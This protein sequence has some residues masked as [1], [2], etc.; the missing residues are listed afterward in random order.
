MKK[1]LFSL[2]VV[3]AALFFAYSLA[4]LWNGFRSQGQLRA[5]ADDRLV[6]DTLHRSATL[7]DDLRARLERLAELARAREIET[8]LANQDLGM[9]PMYGLNANLEAIRER[10]T[11][12]LEL[13]RTAEGL[14]DFRRLIFLDPK[15][16]PLA[17]TQEDGTDWTTPAPLPEQSPVVTID[18]R[19]RK[20]LL[21]APIRFKSVPR[22]YLAAIGNFEAMA[23]HIQPIKG[24]E[25]RVELLLQAGMGF[26]APREV[27]FS[28]QFLAAMAGGPQGKIFSL[29]H[30]WSLRVSGGKTLAVKYL[31]PG[32]GLS[33]ITL[34]SDASLYGHITS[35]GFLLA[36]SLA[37]PLL[38]LGAILFEHQ[39]RR[40]ARLSE[41]VAETDRRRLELQRINTSLEEE[42][43]KRREVEASLHRQRRIQERLTI[44][45]R[46][47]KLQAEAA[48]RA[49]S[50][51][52]ANMSHEIRTPMN[53]I[54]GMAHLCL[55]TQLTTQQQD[56]LEKIDKA[57]HSLL[58]ILN[59]ILD[60]SKIEAGR[61]EMEVGPF[62]LDD[63]ID[64]LSTLMAFRAQEKGLEFL[65]DVDPA[66]P[67]HLV[68]DALRLEQVLVNLAGNAVKFTSKGEVVIKAEL[69]WGN[70][71]EIQV[72]F[73]VRDTG[74]G[75]EQSQID[76]L[77]Q[78][79][80]QA[81][82]STTRRFGGT[83]LGLSI[84]RRLAE[85]MRGRISVTSRP[86]IGS[87]FTFT[88]VFGVS[89]EE[90]PEQKRTLP[91]ELRDGLR[92]LVADD[93]AVA[94]EIIVE[95]LASF[96][97]VTEGVAS[98][99]EALERLSE[100]AIV[101][102][103]YQLL[104]LDWRM[105]EMDGLEVA[106]R[107][108]ESLSAADQP[109]IILI[110]AF[111]HPHLKEE[112]QARRLDGYMTK[113]FSHSQLYD[114]IVRAFG[115]QVVS[116]WRRKPDDD[117]AFQTMLAA[118]RGTR[119]LLVEDN[120]INQQVGRELLALAGFEV[121]IAGHGEEALELLNQH[122]FRAVLM[123]L[124][125]P[126]LDG[127]GAV[128]RIRANPAWD[129]L[130]VIAMTANAISSERERCLAAGMNDYISKP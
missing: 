8:Y 81:D 108:R 19:H 90:Q 25:D 30:A 111:G 114:T 106:R 47:S 102:H 78:P 104:V 71:T 27:Q 55:R 44:E 53:A 33:W 38:L 59:D 37:P 35:R 122:P 39:R 13:S 22:G 26:Y 51:F 49:K 4:L 57:A 128:K 89:R 14:A 40:A 91:P 101:G 79:F 95:A 130:P 125:M 54:I 50:E 119:L 17:D 64:H 84:S 82:A 29:P 129:A 87:Q 100:A 16:D 68:G 34:V 80:S 42:I 5:A 12:A 85:M 43:T 60:F 66:I 73:V 98:G 103:P 48:N 6:N 118:L 123:D 28:P 127:Y 120:E 2:P 75:L 126:V 83:G 58:R 7:Q 99:K 110:T 23:W 32:T 11:Q 46:A 112:A 18:L 63:V 24:D 113:P 1:L 62:C 31:L 61:L 41:R 124:Q 77:F 117:G 116:N 97:F 86:G 9:S 74:I 69:D 36:S 107:T 92:V 21:L 52:L 72:R 115:G 109:R 65:H 45:L 70:E 10:L 121:T 93:N 56:Y 96:S 3:L 105:P 88:A 15:G 67:V 20:L 94:R 76:K